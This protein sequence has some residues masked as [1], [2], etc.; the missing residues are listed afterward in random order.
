LRENILNELTELMVERFHSKTISCAQRAK[1]FSIIVDCTPVV[2]HVQQLSRI[3]VININNENESCERLLPFTF[4]DECSGKGLTDVKLKFLEKNKL[5]F[6][7][8]SAQGHDN[9]ANMKDENSGVQNKILYQNPMAFFMP[10]G[11]HD[12]EFLLCDA[13]KSSVKWYYLYRKE[14]SQIVEVISPPV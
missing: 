4:I 10:C 5:E 9:A 11:C 12:L 8:C 2:S 7:H 3:K 6:K 14:F 1:Y 13:A